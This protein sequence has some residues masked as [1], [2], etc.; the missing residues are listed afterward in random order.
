MT[1]V[2]RRLLAPVALCAVLVGSCTREGG[3]SDESAA[4]LASHAGAVAAPSRPS[5]AVPIA[6]LAHLPCF[7]PDSLR[8][9]PLT[10][11]PIDQSEESGDWSGVEFSFTTAGDTIIGQVRDARGGLPPGRPLEELSYDAV[12]DSLT[13]SYGSGSGTRYIHR[14]RPNCGQLTGVG[15]LFVTPENPAGTVVADTFPRVEHPPAG[16]A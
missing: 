14:L 5:G 9:R 4:R 7:A 16:A 12:T 13:L 11:G 6:S 1:R 10:F 3:E 15:R 8:A 2:R